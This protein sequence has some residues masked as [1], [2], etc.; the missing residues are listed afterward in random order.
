MPGSYG[1]YSHTVPEQW[2]PNFWLPNTSSVG[3]SAIKKCCASHFGLSHEDWRRVCEGWGKFCESD[4]GL[5]K[6]NGLH[7]FLEF[8]PRPLGLG[9][10]TSDDSGGRVMLES[11]VTVVG[12]HDDGGKTGTLTGGFSSTNHYLNPTKKY[13]VILST[14]NTAKQ[15]RGRFLERRLP[16]LRAPDELSN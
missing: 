5:I 16:N 7:A 11:Q 1:R 3:P 12:N 6:E 2:L 4:T 14:N 10:Y 8:I 13:S 9:M 15:I